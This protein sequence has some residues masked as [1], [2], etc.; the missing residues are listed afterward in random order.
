MATLLNHAQSYL[1]WL[2]FNTDLLMSARTKSK[3]LGIPM[4]MRQYTIKQYRLLLKGL[5]KNTTTIELDLD[6]IAL[7][8]IAPI[9]HGIPS[10]V[11]CI[12]LTGSL[13]HHIRNG[14]MKRALDTICFKPVTS[15]HLHYQ[16]YFG[17]NMTHLNKE[18]LIQ[19]LQSMQRN[20]HIA[21]IIL[22]DFWIHDCLTLMPY[23]PQGLLHFKAQITSS[24]SLINLRSLFDNMPKTVETIDLADT[25]K[26]V[27]RIEGANPD[28]HS[29]FSYFPSS[30]HTLK[31]S[32]L[33]HFTF[34]DIP[35]IERLK[36]LAVSYILT[37]LLFSSDNLNLSISLS[38]H[39]FYFLIY[40]IG[41]L[42][43][44]NS[45][46]WDKDN[47]DDRAKRTINFLESL[48]NTLR[49]LDLR[50]CNTKAFTDKRHLIAKAVKDLTHPLRI[51]VNHHSL[52]LFNGKRVA[53]S[54]FFKA[55]RKINDTSINRYFGDARRATNLGDNNLLNMIEDY[56]DSAQAVTAD[57]L[58][59]STK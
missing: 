36:N 43:E 51:T 56:G 53:I 47:I 44:T 17:F 59:L 54:K 2:Q 40:V 31:L 49:H 50:D 58:R 22:E 33:P 13:A 11:T 4:L 46:I 30:I 34:D 52:T 48:P 28:W 25:L 15:L 35:L 24:V 1:A 41:M 37:A 3:T 55:A 9:I 32:Y 16:L 21:N 27:K 5:S 12:K 10:H 39:A 57:E 6:E 42:F 7:S 14:K 20:P 26:Y 23:L 18:E 19:H 45:A 8:H 38:W 29:A